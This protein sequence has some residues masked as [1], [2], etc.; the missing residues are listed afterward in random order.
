[1]Y[2]KKTVLSIVTIVLLKHFHINII[3][4]NFYCV[5]FSLLMSQSE[6]VIVRK[7][8][9]FQ[10]LIKILKLLHLNKKLEFFE[11]N[12]SESTRFISRFR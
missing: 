6:I 9:I 5:I 12:K 3:C 8:K 7:L 2:F 1:M 10:L 4:K 11:I